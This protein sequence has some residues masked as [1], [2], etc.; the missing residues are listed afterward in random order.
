MLG[1]D[2]AFL[3]LKPI[4]IT[5]FTGLCRVNRFTFYCFNPVRI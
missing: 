5:D 2:P 4:A 3:C 1:F